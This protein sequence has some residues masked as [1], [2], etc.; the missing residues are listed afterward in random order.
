MLDMYKNFFSTRA[1][2]VARAFSVLVNDFADTLDTKI[3]LGGR[4]KKILLQN[5]KYKDLY[6]N[7]PGIVI[8]NGPSLLNNNLEGLEA[9]VTFAASGFYK[10]PV[11]ENWSPTF[12][13]FMDKAYFADTNG[14]VEFFRGFNERIS[15]E[16]TMI[17]PIH[18]GKNFFAQTK[19]QGK[20]QLS[21]FASA[22]DNSL[23]RE[24]D[25]STV[26][27]TLYGTSALALAWAVFCGC[28]PI[29][30]LGFDHDY[31]ANRGL[32]K[33]FYEGG[34]M[35]G[36]DSNV[37]LADRVPYDLEMLMN[38]KLWQ[39]YRWLAGCAK[40]NGQT[41]INCTNGGYLDVFP[42]QDWKTIKSQLV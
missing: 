40:K 22:G 38:Y 16:T 15:D 39:N 35:P 11:I 31:L 28:N 26:V 32:D 13:L 20:R 14:P 8:M 41:I 29:Y 4:N 6:K 1:A 30:L 9:S 23:G 7:E 19:D 34:T 24:C 27:P 42:R 37:P 17:A 36:G 18:R 5:E 2:R 10:H 3:D 21:Y 25:F 33:H 12:Y